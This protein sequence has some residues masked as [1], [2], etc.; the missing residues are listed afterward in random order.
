M[1]AA[2]S[3]PFQE[4]EELPPVWNTSIH[5]TYISKCNHR[6]LPITSNVINWTTEYFPFQWLKKNNNKKT[7]LYFLNVSSWTG[8]LQQVW[9]Y[10]VEGK[11]DKMPQSEYSCDV[12]TKSTLLFHT[13]IL[14]L[15]FPLQLSSQPL[16]VA[17]SP[18]DTWLLQLEYG[19]VCLWRTRTDKQHQ[20]HHIH[21][22]KDPYLL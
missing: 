15:A 11:D 21:L 4:E 5:V 8:P 17:V 3:E 13:S 6:S 12:P 9:H 14:H 16:K 1:G 22:K 20:K 2:W 19:E 10:A 7:P 18:P